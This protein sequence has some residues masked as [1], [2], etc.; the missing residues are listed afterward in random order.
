MKTSILK[1]YYPVEISEDVV[2]PDYYVSVE[3]EYHAIRDNVGIVDGGSFGLYQIEGEDAT[4]F[5]DKI[6]TKEI[7]YMIAGMTVECLM[8]DDNANVLGM[9]F[10]QK[11][12]EQYLVIVPPESNLVIKKWLFDKVEGNCNIL[13]ISEEKGFLFIEGRKAWKLIKDTIDFDVESLVL[14][15]IREVEY[16]NDKLLLSRLSRTGEY[17]YTVM[18]NKET[19][20]KFLDK[21]FELREQYGIQ[22]C[23]KRAIEICMLE[24]RAI[25][26]EYE[27]P[28]EGSIFELAQQWLVSYGK[29]N[30]IGYDALQD[31]LNQEKA[32]GTVGFVCDKEF[33]INPGDKVFLEEE[34]IG[35]VIYNFF[36]Y[37]LDMNLGIAKLRNDLAVSGIP[38][39]IKKDTIEVQIKTVSSPFL[40]PKSW[41]EAML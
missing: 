4:N 40:R 1:K 33:E 10:V 18:G 39:T 14:R 30:Y 3:D 21:C 28:Q 31:L 22:L 35:K 37:G 5:L 12:D 16:E 2:Y 25:N 9:V 27:T 15:G 19:L 29:E 34:Y 20:A 6:T 38:L 8:L 24:I 41:D 26:A 23:G 7:V 17:G 13:D 32:E 36:S 11:I